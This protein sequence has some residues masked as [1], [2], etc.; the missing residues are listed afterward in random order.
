MKREMFLF[1]AIRVRFKSATRQYIRILSVFKY[2]ANPIPPYYS[3]IG[4]DR[5]KPELQYSTVGKIFPLSVLQHIWRYTLSRGKYITV[6]KFHTEQ[7]LTGFDEHT[8]TIRVNFMTE[9]EYKYMPLARA[10]LWPRTIQFRNR[11]N[12]TGQSRVKQKYNSADCKQRRYVE[13]VSPSLFGSVF[14]FSIVIHLLV[15]ALWLWNA[16]WSPTSLKSQSNSIPVLLL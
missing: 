2:V 16:V 11:I 5:W 8:T 12:L 14:Y 15:L 13:H 3:M 7:S 1:F 9:K 4:I 10:C 6:Y